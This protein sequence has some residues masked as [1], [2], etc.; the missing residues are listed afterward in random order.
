MSDRLQ[1]FYE[2]PGFIK[3]LALFKEKY[4]SL[5]RIGGTVSIAAFT[6]EEVE[7]IAGFLG[8]SADHMRMKGKLSLADFERELRQTIFA[9]YTLIQ[10]M[11]EVFQESIITKQEEQDFSKQMEQAFFQRLRE[12]YP[13][14]NWWWDR[15][16]SKAPDSRWIWSLYHQ[17]PDGL[18]EQLTT[19]Y[20]AFEQLPFRKNK[21]ERL[22][23]FAQRITS[24][25]HSFD[26]HQI[27]GK[28]L[29]YILQVHQQ[30]MG[31]REPGMPKTTEVLNDLL[32]SYGVL[33]DDL[34]SFVSCRGFLAAG[35]YGVNPVWK[36]AAEMNTVLNVP[37]KELLKLRK[38]WPARGK[39][40]WIVENSSV[41]STILDEVPFAPVICSHGQFR[42][43]SW[44]LF[45]FLV[46]EGCSLYYSGDLDPEGLM[47]ADRL[48]RRYPQQVKFWHMDLKSYNEVVSEEDISNRM[49]KIEAISS[50]ELAEVAEAL[51][52][53]K[54]AGYQEGLLEKLVQDIN[55]N[56]HF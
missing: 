38:V 1:V 20:Q 50:P 29:T 42:T 49:T 28:L 31:F 3:L 51:K 39:K 15:I 10:L 30:H 47:M 21:Y 2:E 55:L 17:D 54:K 7:S 48:K 23:L 12:A 16:E 44:V 14:G 13:N 25:P 34:W 41:C 56:M 36:S 35:D 11:E 9:D 45:D 27:G 37:I 46:K 22:P 4:R 5:G 53:R 43:A 6:R 18:F 26:S 32:S 52:N 40:V 33:R 24:N 19:V 8:E